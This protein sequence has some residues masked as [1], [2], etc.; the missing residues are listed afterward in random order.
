MK[1][2]VI[3]GA[4]SMI[5]VALIREC[6][7]H[8]VE[9]LA[10]VRKNTD[11]LERIPKSNKI[12]IYKCDLNELLNI[13]INNKYDVFYHFA[14][15]NTKKIYRDNP[16]LQEINIKYTLDAVNLAKKL[17]C[18]KFIG[19]G[20][21][22]EYGKTNEIIDSETNINPITSYGI[23][24]YAAGMLS[25]KL[26][27]KYGIIHIWGRIFSVYGCYDNEG[28]MLVYA[29]KQFINNKVAKF[30]SGMQ[31]WNYLFEEDAG[32]IFY[33]LG[34]LVNENKVFCIANKESKKLKEYIFEMI[35]CFEKEFNVK[36]EYTFNEVINKNDINLKVDIDSLIK[37]INYVPETSFK[38][39]ITKMIDYL[40]NTRNI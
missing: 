1:K 36:V 24:K 39:G 27:Q 16:L 7:K 25:R 22:A 20:S 4:T 14:W 10:I 5:G 21:Q 28:T 13:K 18:Y 34:E 35:N 30:S 6:I 33:F 9:V 32:K 3:T 23:S 17:K 15:A 37:C 29:I 40:I 11:R 31:F 2:V 12:K 8:D 26:C 38:T 19:A